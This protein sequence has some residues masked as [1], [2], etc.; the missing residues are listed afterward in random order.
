VHDRIAAGEV[1]T[2]RGN[3]QRIGSRVSLEL[4]CEVVQRHRVHQGKKHATGD[5]VDSG[6]RITSG[7]LGWRGQGGGGVEEL[8][9]HALKEKGSEGGQAG[10]DSFG[11]L[12]AVTEER[13]PAT[14]RLTADR[15]CMASN[16]FP[17][18]EDTPQRGK[19]E[20]GGRGVVTRLGKRRGG[21]AVPTARR[22]VHGE[23]GGLAGSPTRAYL[24]WKRKN[25]QGVR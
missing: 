3:E 12:P 24:G 23:G 13:W 14:G 25:K 15:L 21:G 17:C 16:F 7:H 6:T 2:S 10:R 8:L 22:M 18:E 4:W 11:Q 1:R 20:Q 9:R 5:G 19:M